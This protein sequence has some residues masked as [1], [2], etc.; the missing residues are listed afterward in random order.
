MR[1]KR[2]PS[3]WLCMIN[4]SPCMSMNGN[5]FLSVWDQR[6]NI[7][8]IFGKT[9]YDKHFPMYEYE[10]WKFPLSMRPKTKHYC[11]LRTTMYDKHFPKYEYEAITFSCIC[12][13]PKRKHYCNLGMPMYDKHFPNYEY[14][15]ITFS[16]KYES[17]EKILLYDKHIPKYGY[18]AITFSSKYESGE[19]ILL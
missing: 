6:E 5:I 10:R 12:M 19:K 8:V 2:K 18:E 11:N 1:P 15:A 16:C 3:A 14:E 4:I 7:T 9:L 17:D 13:R